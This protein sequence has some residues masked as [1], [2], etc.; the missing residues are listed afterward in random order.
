MKSPWQP[1]Y[2]RL[3]QSYAL[4]E[5]HLGGFKVKNAIALT[6]MACIISFKVMHELK[7]KRLHHH[8]PQ[9]LPGMDEQ[10]NK[11]CKRRAECFHR[12]LVIVLT[13]HGQWQASFTLEKLTNKLRLV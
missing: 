13:Q 8:M 1:A 2:Y 6:A 9:C 12:F 3:L 7:K 10:V 4:Y 5:I 11:F